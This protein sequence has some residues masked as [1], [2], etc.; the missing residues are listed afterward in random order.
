MPS[1]RMTIDEVCADMRAHG[2]SITNQTVS[3]AIAAGAFKF[4]TVVS[5]G[6]TGKRNI[7]IMR[8]D[9]EAWAAE[10]LTC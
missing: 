2:M 3:D 9:Y 5:V 4:G 10:Y 1:P 8:K 6:P 7:I